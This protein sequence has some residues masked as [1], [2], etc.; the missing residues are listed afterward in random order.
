MSVTQNITSWTDHLNAE[1]D[2]H[3]TQQITVANTADNSHCSPVCQRSDRRTIAVPNQS[4]PARHTPRLCKTRNDRTICSDQL[5][6]WT[7][8]INNSFNSP[9][10]TDQHKNVNVYSL[11]QDIQN[12]VSLADTQTYQTTRLENISCFTEVRRTYNYKSDDL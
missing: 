8:Q 4:P 11:S 9:S 1:S 5:F 3:I 7:G 2:T 10:N 12:C 6:Y